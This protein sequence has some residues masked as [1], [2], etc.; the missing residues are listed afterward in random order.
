MTASQFFLEPTY[1]AHLLVPR[2]HEGSTPDSLK[3]LLDSLEDNHEKWHVYFHEMGYHNHIAHHL[4]TLYALGAPASI[5]KKAYSLESSWQRPISLGLK[6]PEIEPITENNFF[7]HL[8]DERYFKAYVDYFEPVVA[9]LGPIA[10]LEKYVYAR[11]YNYIKGLA[12]DKEQP[13]ML[14]RHMAAILHPMIQTGFGVEFG[15][16]GL[17][18]EGLAQTAVHELK[19]SV[20]IPLFEPSSSKT[21][22][23]SRSESPHALTILQTLL[24]SADPVLKPA[25]P[26]DV[27]IQVYYDFC[28]DAAPAVIPLVDEWLADVMNL[29]GKEGQE[30]ELKKKLEGKVEEVV[31]ANTIMYGVGG[32]SSSRDYNADFFLMHIVTSAIF[33]PSFLA[34]L[35]PVATI[36]LLKAFFSTSVLWFVGRGRPPINLVEFYECTQHLIDKPLE[37]PISVEVPSSVKPHAEAE[38]NVV[39]S[40]G[41]LQNPWT[42]ILEA[43]ITHPDEHLPKLQRSLVHWAS[44]YGHKS[45]K[46]DGTSSNKAISPAVSKITLPGVLTHLDGTLFL[47]VAALSAVRMEKDRLID[48]VGVQGVQW[49]RAGLYNR[50]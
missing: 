30:E 41:L 1:L 16:P 27:L 13:D 22:R 32:W 12:A 11:E 42:P 7:E 31:W 38:T 36:N 26:G 44:V 14:T 24:S 2:Q 34:T 19:T 39:Q 6:S 37:M 29:V 35:Q 25:D 47:R 3:L 21:A 20:H 8:G 50:S 46:Q 33:L 43:S 48:M 45:F 15:F 9:R 18:V 28:M 49:D 17:V 10:A 4:I 23:P 5:I 40:A